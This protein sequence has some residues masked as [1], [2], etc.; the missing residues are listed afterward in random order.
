[1]CSVYVSFK[2][3]LHHEIFSAFQEAECKMES[4]DIS[5]WQIYWKFQQM[6]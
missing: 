5:A 2:N 1:M 6:C 3:N 4:L